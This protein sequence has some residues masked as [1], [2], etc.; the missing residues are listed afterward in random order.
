MSM[1]N[2]VPP[3]RRT[4][5]LVWWLSVGLIIAGF[6]AWLNLSGTNRLGL[7]W[8]TKP[9]FI[10]CSFIIALA[11]LE[12]RVVKIKRVLQVVLCLL[13]AILLEYLS[14]PRPIDSFVGITLTLLGLTILHG[15]VHKYRV[16]ELLFLLVC[17]YIQSVCIY[18]LFRGEQ[19]MFFFK[20]GWTM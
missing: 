4:S 14:L 18:N 12:L 19:M 1:N 20:P 2:A 16:L 9:G 11:A 17:A 10:V 8:A 3:A 13:G 15:S 5:G 6:Y 7:G